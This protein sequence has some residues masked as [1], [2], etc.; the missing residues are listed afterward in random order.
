MTTLNL[1]S[2]FTRLK[3]GSYLAGIALLMTSFQVQAETTQPDEGGWSSY[4]PPVVTPVWIQDP[5]TNEVALT[6]FPE[7]DYSLWNKSRIE[8]Y[9]A[10]LKMDF[11]PPLAILTIDKLNLQVPI[12]NGTDDI[13][14]DRGAGRIKGMAKMDEVGNL[15]ISGH[16]D[17]FFRG[18]KDI[19]VGDSIDIQTPQGTE[20]YEVT[21]IFIVPKEDASVLAPTEDKRLTVVT[22]Y[23]FYYVGNAPKRL[24]VTALPKNSLAKEG[25]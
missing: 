3:A 13:T 22:C 5:W 19:E 16:R 23:P 11:P 6:S 14:L 12:F 2:M 15:G 17:G 7:P 8:D 18:M 21:E 24:I 20:N 10:S 25:E 4:D 1:K 9:E